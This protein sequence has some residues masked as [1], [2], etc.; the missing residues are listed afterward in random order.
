MFERTQTISIRS[1]YLLCMNTIY[2]KN[3]SIKMP[4][5][6]FCMKHK[7]SDGI[8]NKTKMFQILKNFTQKYYTKDVNKEGNWSIKSCIQNSIN[9]IEV[10]I[11]KWRIEGAGVK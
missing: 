7:H 11:L 8:V 5:V 3:C 1:H 10:S 9:P 4:V 2:W 6:F